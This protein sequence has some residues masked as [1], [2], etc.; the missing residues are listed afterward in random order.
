MSVFSNEV[1]VEPGTTPLPVD[2]SGVTQPI[3][4]VSLPLPSGAATATKQDTGNASLASI[5]SKL[6]NPLP[7][8]F[9]TAATTPTQSQI[10][11][12]SSIST[13]LLAANANRKQIL[14]FC[15]K[16]TAYITYGATANSTNWSRIAIAANTQFEIEDGYRGVISIMSTVNQTVTV[17]ELA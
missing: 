17:T 4:A 11:L 13:T 5:D 14:L 15:P 16:A 10:V 12:S 8:S 6:T 9:A 2:G 3:S 1:V 7:V